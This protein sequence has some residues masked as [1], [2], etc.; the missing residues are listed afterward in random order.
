MENA[1]IDPLYRPIALD[2]EKDVMNKR[3]KITPA[4]SK[5]WAIGSTGK[6][7][8]IGDYDPGRLEVVYLVQLDDRDISKPPFGQYK[9][10]E[11]EIE[12]LPE[13]TSDPVNHPSYYTDGKYEVID[14]IESRPVLSEDFRL[15]NAAKYLSRAGKKDPDKKQ[16]DLEKALWYME[17]YLEKKD[18]PSETILLNEYI[19]EKGLEDTPQGLALE[20][21]IKGDVET[22]V[23]ILK[24]KVNDNE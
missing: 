19:K 17:R 23:R 21:L 15:G 5:N 20:F 22:A 4:S 2:L 14:F 13:H 10:F 7:V 11:S 24:M 8:G 12:F 16:E 1:F 3:V 6:I 9:F 18:Q